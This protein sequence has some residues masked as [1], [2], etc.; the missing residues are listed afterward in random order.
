[1]E[2]CVEEACKET[3]LNLSIM[4]ECQLAAFL[5]PLSYGVHLGF[6]EGVRYAEKMNSAT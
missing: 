5:G 6:W 4:T 3:G 1:M 2:R